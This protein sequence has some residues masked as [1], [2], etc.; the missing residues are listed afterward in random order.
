M[1]RI[2]NNNYYVTNGWMI[3]ELGL[4]GRELQV[5]AIIYGFTQDEETEF[6]GSLNYIAEW[7][8][9]SSRH[10]V[11]RAIESLLEKGLIG[12]RQTATGGII[13]NFYKAI[14]PPPPR[15]ITCVE[16]AQGSAETTQG[17]CRNGTGDSAKT[18]QGGCVETAHNKDI[19]KDSNKYIN[20][21]LSTNSENSTDLQAV[22]TE[23]APYLKITKLYNDTCK[24]FPKCLTLSEARKK[25][26]KARWREYGGNLEPFVKLFTAAEA[27]SF[28][29]GKN[30]RNWSATFDWL[31]KSTNMAKVLEGNYR[32]KGGPKNERYEP[33]TGRNGGTQSGN[34]G[35]A[36]TQAELEAR[37]RTEGS[38]KGYP[39]FDAM[40]AGQNAAAGGSNE[41]NT[42]Q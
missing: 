16:T 20:N 3:N 31:L 13:T 4:T 6:S 42:Q 29:K 32:D 40:F 36:E 19:N 17:L 21:P 33:G 15:Q 18:A 41:C 12:K 22:K 38:F 30:D 34:H 35:G 25:A 37:L 28:L 10:T 27:S 8:G 11:I 2:K 23:T 24:S 7:L 26:I 1:G 39:D 14:L 9:T 5:Y